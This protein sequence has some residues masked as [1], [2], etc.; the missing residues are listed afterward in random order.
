MK[1]VLL[2]RLSAMGDLVQGLGAVASLAARRPDLRLTFVTQEPLLPLLQG[3]PGLSR[4]V[5]FQRDGGWRGL[6]RLRG[7]LRQD[8]Y[9]CALDLQGNWKSAWI[10]RLSGAELCLG[11]GAA[12]RQEPWSRLL[13]HRTLAIEGV[14]HPARVAWQLV[15]AVEPQATWMRPRLAATAAEVAAERAA[16][17]GAGIDP[18]R[19][20]RVVVAT[21]PRDPRGLHPR[22]VATSG[23]PTLL[24]CGPAEAGLAIAASDVVLRH[25]AGEPRR[26]I[27][28]AE[29][30]R[31]AGGAVLGPDGGAVH[32]LAAAGA[33]CTVVFGAQDPCRTAPPTAVAVRHPDPPSCSPCRRRRCHHPRGPVC[34]EFELAQGRRVD[35]GLPGE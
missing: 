29:V 3:L 28:L 23:L 1:S 32:V 8:R 2:V 30:V 33:A 20:F 9:D 16:V 4:V 27:A 21:D 19:P 11:A 12:A 22:C 10:A 31:Q 5:G 15:R 25:G 26:L 24:L 13:L 35:I 17:R 14:P 34:M 18:D 6:L 7:Q